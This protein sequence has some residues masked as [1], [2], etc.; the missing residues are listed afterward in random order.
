ML[1][2]YTPIPNI[3]IDINRL[4]EEIFHYW[5]PSNNHAVSFTTAKKY[6]DDLNYDFSHYEV[7]SKFFPN[8]RRIKVYEDGE[9]DQNIVHWPKILENSYMKELGDYFAKILNVTRYRARG[10]YFDTKTHMTSGFKT[11]L[12]RDPHTPYRIHIALKTSPEVNWFLVDKD[13]NSHY[14]H[15]PADGVPILLETCF[16]QHQVIVPPDSVRMHFWFQYYTEFDQAT[17]DK[18]FTV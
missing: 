12:H 8:T 13:N 17:I 11:D 14:I 10:S 15:Q 5:T 4:T 18:L 6:V 2:F 1:D 7:I 16:T 3:K 9:F